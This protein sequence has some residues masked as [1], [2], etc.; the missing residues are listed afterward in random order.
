MLAG[1]AR[2]LLADGLLSD[3]DQD[4]LSFLEQVG[5]ERH[6]SAAGCC[7][8]GVHHRHHRGVR[9]PGAG[10]RIPDAARVGCSPRFRPVRE[11]QRG[12]PF[13]A[14]GFGSQCRFRFGLGFVE[15]SFVFRFFVHLI[16]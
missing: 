5:N 13:C 15:L 11:L 7:A 16:G 1:D 12:P 8:S 4:F 10:D 2:A 6:Y 14:A 9:A 3:L